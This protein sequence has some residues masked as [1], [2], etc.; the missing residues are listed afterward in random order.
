MTY[1]YNKYLWVDTY[2]QTLSN[3]KIRNYDLLIV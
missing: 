3:I 2:S 1:Y